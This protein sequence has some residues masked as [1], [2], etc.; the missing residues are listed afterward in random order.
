M[1]IP[2]RHLHCRLLCAGL[3]LVPTLL[4][5]N[6]PPDGI[7]LLRYGTS[8]YPQSLYREDGPEDILSPFSW[9]FFLV[10]RGDRLILI[11]S[12]FSEAALPGYVSLFHLEGHVEPER[13]LDRL[14]VNPERIT[15][16]IVTHSHFDHA[17]GAFLFANTKTIVHMQRSEWMAF[18]EGDRDPA[19]R[20]VL[21][22]VDAEGRLH[23]VDGTENLTAWLRLEKTGGHSPGSQAV[24]VT[25]NDR[26]FVFVGDECYFARLCRDGTP[27]P[28]KSRHSREANLAFLSRFARGPGGGDSVTV[29]PSHDPESVKTGTPVAEN[30][31]RLTGP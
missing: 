11:D 30:I 2:R 29:L 28:E 21:E 22:Q 7:Y 27:L 16:L 23:L 10:K 1:N 25:W 31:W 4:S 3:L 9:D 17:G 20:S 26:P 18:L 12:G 8:L 6:R 14:G 13:M 15:D 24:T 19:L 5:C